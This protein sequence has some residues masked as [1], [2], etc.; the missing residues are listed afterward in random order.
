MQIGIMASISEVI[1]FDTAELV[2]SELGHK[3]EPE[4]VLTEAEAL[5]GDS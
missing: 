5:F 3:V 4:I 2:A 1:D